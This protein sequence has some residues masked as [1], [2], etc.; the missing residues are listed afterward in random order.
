MDQEMFDKDSKQY[1]SELIL[2][3]MVTR[4]RLVEI[5]LAHTTK[6]DLKDILDS[7]E[8]SPR[9]LFPE[10]YDDSQPD[11]AQEW[12]DYNPDC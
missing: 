4:E 10:D 3:E 7:E 5:L 9:F 12:H 2:F 1:V 6:D 11:E 8:L